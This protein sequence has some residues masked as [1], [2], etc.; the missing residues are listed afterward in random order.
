ME[1]SQAQPAI[2]VKQVSDWRELH[3]SSPGEILAEAER[4]AQRSADVRPLGNLTLG[5]AFKHLALT[6]NAG[7]DGFDFTVPAEVQAFAIAHKEQ[8]FA[9]RM[10]AGTKLPPAGVAQ[11]IPAACSPEEGLAELRPAIARLQAS[12]PQQVHPYLGEL[13]AAEW[14][15]LH[16]RHAELHLGFMLL[17]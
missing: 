14:T 1:G 6:I 5:Q 13:T 17:P 3:F 4:L 16:C 10:R 2:D 7:F 15:S 12:T 9:G 11:F 8:M